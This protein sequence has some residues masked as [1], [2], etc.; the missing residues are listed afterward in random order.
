[1]NR[2]IRDEVGAGCCASG[3]SGKYPGMSLSRKRLDVS[4]MS[5]KGESNRSPCGDTV[6]CGGVSVTNDGAR[7]VAVKAEGIG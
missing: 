1:M 5:V 4:E 7:R 3:V 2:G 6:R